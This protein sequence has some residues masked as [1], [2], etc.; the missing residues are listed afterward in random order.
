MDRRNIIIT[1]AIFL[2]VVLLLWLG[3]RMLKNNPGDT[4]GTATS[5]VSLFPTGEVRPDGVGQGSLFDNLATSTASNPNLSTD[6][7]PPAERTGRFYRI[8]NRPIGGAVQLSQNVA[9]SSVGNLIYVEKSTGHLFRLAGTAVTPE[10]ISNTTIPKIYNLA[11]G[12]TGTTTHII[13]QYL[14]N[15]QV[16]TFLGHLSLP[17]TV[18]GEAFLNTSNSDSSNPDAEPIAGALLANNIS[19]LAVAPTQDKLLLLETAP[20]NLATNAILLDLKSNKRETLTTLP[21][22]E[23]RAAWAT[24]SIL[25]LQTSAA[26]NHLGSLYWYNLKT[27]K[28]ELVITSV[29]GLTT[30]TSPKV[31]KIFYSGQVDNKLVA[32]FYSPSQKF[33]S[34]LN[35]QTWA[36][37]CVWTR[38]GKT[39]YCAAPSSLPPGDYPDTWY[40]GE[41]SVSDNLWK[42]DPA[43]GKSELI[44][45]PTLGQTGL[46]IDAE[47]L[48][49]ASDESTL[50]LTNRQDGNLWALSLTGSF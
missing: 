29:P 3:V 24:S 34:R 11:A 16:Q 7:L 4:V 33:F 40:R 13:F 38:D 2:L 10:R 36:D 41:A 47:K 46:Q 42:I 25:T 12:Q 21:L 14:K 39:L 18:T 17:T 30:L 44:Y 22:A 32:G 19:S 8:S 6:E 48:T 31:D 43:T 1:V 9:T 20:N 50:Y 27:K 15:N 23:W 49:L 45:N 28:L 26:S 35:L 5:T 37:K